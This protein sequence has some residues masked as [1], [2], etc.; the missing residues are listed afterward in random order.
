MTT[1]TAKG[2]SK[3]K[4]TSSGHLSEK[5][6]DDI[7]TLPNMEVSRLFFLLQCGQ[8]PKPEETKAELL[9]IIEKDSK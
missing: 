5:V 9:K 4:K 1:T 8:D 2:D 6:E 7:A 3:K